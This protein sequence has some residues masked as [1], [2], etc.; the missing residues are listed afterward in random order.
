[1]RDWIV[2]K[3]I[4]AYLK[5][6]FKMKSPNTTTAGGVVGLAFLA[7]IDFAKL[8]HCDP[9]EIGKLVIALG[10]MAMGFFAKDKGAV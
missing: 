6:M 10:T 8:F 9:T 7:Q 5:G 2:N 3:F 1:M 4:H